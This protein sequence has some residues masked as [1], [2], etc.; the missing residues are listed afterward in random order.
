M[1]KTT[2]KI[3]R[4]VI[5]L[6]LFCL[7][8]VVIFA[9]FSFQIHR[10]IG[11][12]LKLLE[13]TGDMFSNILEARRFEKNF[14]L[15]KQPSSLEEA[16]SYVER[17]MEMYRS[18]EAEILRIKLDPRDREF[19]STLTSYR[20]VLMKLQGLIKP[21]VD[22]EDSPDFT[23]L[24]D[25]MRNLGLNLVQTTERWEK[26][27]RV[28]IDRLFQR[29]MYLFF[30]SILV[31]LG[32]GILVAFYL[33]WVLV[34]PMMQMQQ[35]MERITH[36]DFTA[37][38]EPEGRSEEFISLFRAFNRMIKELEEHQEELLQSRKIAAIGTLTS[39]IAHELNNPINNIVL[40]AE[41]L[42]EDF[43]QL[44]EADVQGYIHDILVQAE[45]ASDIVKGLLDFSR[46]ERPE[47]EPISILSVIDDT[48]K[49]VRNQLM[50]SGI[51]V[52]KEI[53]PEVPLI[54]GDRKS[55]QQ[56]FLNLFIN[57]IQAMPDGGHLVIRVWGDDGKLH[58]DVKDTGQG[59]DPAHLPHIFDP[60]YTTKEV[61]RGTGLGLSVTY[62]IIE[63]HGGHI[64]AHSK[65]G[66]GAV[67]S[68]VLP[69]KKGS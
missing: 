39:G 44:D 68:I 61:G 11:R 6:F 65:K 14:L 20:N 35:A 27:E 41:A 62:G 38:P 31:F 42:K 4:R 60:F 58:V 25:S 2:Y 64:E 49:L 48:L 19:N 47:L 3:R 69:A 16:L 37:L 18:H 51:Q 52:E 36:G 45:R 10:D 17:V 30:I 12:R 43:G 46:S 28:Q 13:M 22:L 33:A 8:S 54:S 50:L 57:A 34:R 29:A 9:G 5:T 67:F 40:T 24:V 23:R 53:A 59:I 66:E 21:G 26:E 15:Y 32:L 7:L 56:V 55:L 1:K 63:K